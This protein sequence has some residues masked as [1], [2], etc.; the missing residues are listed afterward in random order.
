MRIQNREQFLSNIAQNLG[1]SVRTKAER[2]NWKYT[3]QHDILKDATQDELVEVLAKQCQN[4]HTTCHITTSRDLPNVLKHVIDGFGGKSIITWKDER[5]AQ[6]GLN[7][8]FTEL[9]D[10][11][12]I[13]LYEWN[14]QTPEE[15][16]RQAEKANIGITISEMTLAESASAV[17]YSHKH[18]GRTM[19]FLPE[20]SIVLI[21]KSTIVPRIT[22]AA[23]HIHQQIKN[24]E[25]IPSCILFMTGPSNSAD[26]EMVLIVGVHG[27]VKATYIV[28]DD[29]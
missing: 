15:N 2:P 9:Q 19:N 6:L 21:P 22:Q 7:P 8:L 10:E 26:I 28:I 27:P 11:Q 4:I 29:L 25:T 17:L 24:G 23:K 3:P 20:K 5:Y 12:Q 14:E 1:R 18:R 13:E 16:I